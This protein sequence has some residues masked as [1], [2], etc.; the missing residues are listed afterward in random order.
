MKKLIAVILALCLL[1]PAAFGSEWEWVEAPVPVD[2]P[3]LTGVK[4]GIDPG[5]QAKGN[6][7]KEPMA[8][9]SSEMKA[10]VSSG[11]AGVKTR[12]AEYVVNLD[13]SLQLRDA[14]EA[15]GCEVYMTRETHDVNISNK[16]RALMMNDLD[17]DL[18]LRIHCNGANDRSVHGTGLYVTK[19]GDIAGESLAA[20]EVLLPAMI[21]ATGAKNCG[22]FKRDTY[23]GMNWSTVPVILVEMGYMSN[24]EEDVL[25]NDPDYQQKLVDGMVQGII[26]CI[27]I[28]DEAGE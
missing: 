1:A 14:L 22:I 18:V 3:I 11:T 19:T 23:T 27:R 26:D 9:G 8:P 17:V 2:I 28:R 12:V 20:A 10:K 24:P 4:I 25:L 6:S 7:E 21:E 15:L 16:E 5:H 13:V